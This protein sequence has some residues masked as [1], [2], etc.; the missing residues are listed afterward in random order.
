VEK[1][2]QNLLMLKLT[3]MIGVLVFQNNKMPQ[4]ILVHQVLAEITKTQ[5][6][7]TMFYLKDLINQAPIYRQKINLIYLIR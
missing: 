7:T 1:V 5:Q 4:I 2:D 3:E 6:K